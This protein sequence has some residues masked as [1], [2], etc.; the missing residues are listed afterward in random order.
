MA[1][2][3]AIILNCSV[4]CLLSLLFAPSNQFSRYYSYLLADMNYWHLLGI[5]RHLANL[6]FEEFK[7]NCVSRKILPSSS[8]PP[9]LF[10]LTLKLERGEQRVL[11]NASKVKYYAFKIVALQ[12]MRMY[13]LEETG[14]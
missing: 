2:F 14:L 6:L 5:R 4:L 3:C 8:R 13:L 7:Q 12:C 11:K 1:A 10:E 9:N